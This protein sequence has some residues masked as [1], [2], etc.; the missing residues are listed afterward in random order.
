M[1]TTQRRP[2]LRGSVGAACGYDGSQVSPRS[3]EGG[4]IVRD[5]RVHQRR[6]QFTIHATASR[7]HLDQKQAKVQPVRR[8]LEVGLGVLPERA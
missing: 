2:L 5:Q 6:V 1:E 7:R 3:R 8:L 4:S